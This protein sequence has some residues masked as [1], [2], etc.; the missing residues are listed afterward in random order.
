MG[1]KDLGLQNASFTNKDQGEDGT[2]Y[3]NF[4]HVLCYQVSHPIQQQSHIFPR[5]FFASDTPVET[6]LVAAS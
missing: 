6:F 3:F 5:L 4:L 1:L 2:E